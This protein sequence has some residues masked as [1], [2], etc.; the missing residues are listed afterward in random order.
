M[1][2][3]DQKTMKLLLISSKSW[4]TWMTQGSNMFK[5]IITKRVFIIEI[6]V[7]GF[8]I[9]FL[10]DIPNHILGTPQTHASW[11]ENAFRSVIVFLL[12]LYVMF[13][14][15]LLLDAIKSNNEKQRVCPV[16]KKIKMGH[17]W[18]SSHQHPDTSCTEKSS[19]NL[20]RECFNKIIK[21]L[22]YF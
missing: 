5:D 20:C 2:K 14:S 7:F 11:M 13:V 18:V 19:Q 15:W 16:C 22:Q 6:L 4:A 12:G 8:I 17:K 21:Y 10:W 9:L 1:I 3:A